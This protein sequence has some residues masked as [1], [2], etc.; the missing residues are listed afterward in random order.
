MTYIEQY[1]EL[2][3]EY[4]SFYKSRVV[5]L[6][7][8]GVFYEI[9]EIHEHQDDHKLHLILNIKKTIFQRLHYTNMVTMMGFPIIYSDKYIKILLEHNYILVKIENDKADPSL[10]YCITEIIHP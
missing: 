8:M 5:L 6:Q 9:Y 10:R 2:Q 1:F 4:D 3:Q 7:Q